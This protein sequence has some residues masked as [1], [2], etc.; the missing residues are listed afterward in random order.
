MF[1]HQVAAY[2]RYY[3]R[4]PARRRQ[5]L[6]KVAAC[7]SNFYILKGVAA[8]SIH[9]TRSVLFLFVFHIFS[10][11]YS[12]VAKTSKE[13]NEEETLAAID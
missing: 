3:P 11:F 6:A 7:K 4:L 8:P 12:H 10:H 2:V 13:V 5:R 9:S 1:N